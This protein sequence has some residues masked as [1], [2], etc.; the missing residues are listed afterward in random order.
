MGP[1]VVRN[2]LAAGLQIHRPQPLAAGR[3]GAGTG[4]M[5]S[6]EAALRGAIVSATRIAANT[7]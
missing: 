4:T 7:I 2:T 5:G 6:R 1:F 3:R